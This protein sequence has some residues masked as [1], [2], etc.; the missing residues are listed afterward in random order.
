MKENII[1]TYLNY[2]YAVRMHEEYG[3][4]YGDTDDI[5]KYYENKINKYLA[6]TEDINKKIKVYKKQLKDQTNLVFF[7]SIIKNEI[8]SAVMIAQGD[9]AHSFCMGKIMDIDL[10]KLRWNINNKDNWKSRHYDCTK[11]RGRNI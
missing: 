7:W 8:R 1:E 9:K 3:D 11:I 5:I 4:L 2:L 10:K 6:N